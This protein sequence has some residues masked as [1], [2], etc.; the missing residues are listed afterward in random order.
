MFIVTATS[1]RRL[2]ALGLAAAT[3]LIATSNPVR[4]QDLVTPDV[5]GFLEAEWGASPDVCVRA[6]FVYGNDKNDK[7]ALRILKTNQAPVVQQ[8]YDIAADVLKDGFWRLVASSHPNPPA[9]GCTGSE[10][11]VQAQYAADRGSL[12]RSARAYA[13][14][15]PYGGLSVLLRGAPNAA[16]QQSYRACFELDPPHLF[17]IVQQTIGMQP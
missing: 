2:S 11:N 15:G 16:S 5:R 9:P 14:N 10:A 7:D 6:L 3:I 17:K 12:Y 13:A 8:T 1:G 4:A